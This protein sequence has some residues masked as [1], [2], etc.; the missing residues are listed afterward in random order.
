LD[1]EYIFILLQHSFCIFLSLTPCF[2]PLQIGNRIGSLPESV[3]V[4]SF[5][6][7]YWVTEHNESISG[8]GSVCI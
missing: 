4:I 5:I 6:S 1:F 7:V 3:T 2:Q 8:C